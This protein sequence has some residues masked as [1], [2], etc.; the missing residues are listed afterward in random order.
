MD[1]WPRVRISAGSS[2]ILTTP[3]PGMRSSAEMPNDLGEHGLCAAQTISKAVT[4]V[5]NVI[6]QF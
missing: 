1:V 6:C 3:K 4:V 5:R 2:L